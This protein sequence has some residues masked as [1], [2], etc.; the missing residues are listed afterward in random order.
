[1]LAWA[2]FGEQWSLNHKVTFDGLSK[3]ITVQENITDLNIGTEVY[4]A[5]K[6]W[7]LLYNNNQYRPALRAIQDFYFLT[8]GW[9]FEINR[10][11]TDV[12]GY[13]NPG[14]MIAAVKG[15]SGLAAWNV[16]PGAAPEF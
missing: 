4:Q 3:V 1:M 14:E 2:S 16:L 5:W 11:F 7:I 6:Q 8:N 9:T 10:K 15:D 12:T 13:L